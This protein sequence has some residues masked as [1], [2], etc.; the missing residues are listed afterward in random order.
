MKRALLVAR[1]ELLENARTKGFW[2]GILMMPIMLVLLGIV[3]LLVESTREAKQYAVI[4]KSGWLLAEVRKQ[5]EVSDFTV[6]L[7]RANPRM[8]GLPDVFNTLANALEDADGDQLEAAAKRVLYPSESTEVALPNAASELIASHGN[9]MAGYW[10][11]LSPTEKAELSPEISTNRFVMAQPEDN[12]LTY[13]NRLIQEQKLFAYFIIGSDPVESGEGLKYVSNN[14]TDRGLLNWFTGF[15]NTRVREERL[16]QVDMDRETAAW[17]TE[18]V[19]F[20]DIQI[21][22]EGQEQQVGTQDIV[23]QWA[24]VVFVYLL[25]ISILLNT[26]MLLTNMIEEKSNKVIEVLLSSIS[27]VQLMAGKI[28]GIALTG[29]TIIGAWTLMAMLFFILIPSMIGLEIPLDLTSVVSDPIYIGSF[30]VYFVLGYL[31]YAAILVGLG[32]VCSNLK[33]AQNLMLPVQLVQIIPIL[34]MIPIGRDPNGTLAQIMSYIPPLTPFVMMNRAAAPPTT[35]E[36]VVTTALLVA[37]IAVVLWL[38][39]RIFRI[40][41]LFTGKPPGFVGILRWFRRP[42]T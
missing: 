10:R 27:A 31:L 2:I 3:P 35:F 4:D 24:P 17:I 36:Y 18:P 16:K 38:A 28:L 8:S 11:T 41:I 5:I 33:D 7:S 19:S 42:A 9:E 6:L 20:E 21:S 25:W 30:L 1:R 23:R 26:Q 37:S 29:L 13:L 40:G 12:G 15:V 39:A 34:V 32:S 22:S 14:L